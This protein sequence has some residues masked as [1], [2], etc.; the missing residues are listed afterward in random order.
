MLFCY[1]IIP[2]GESLPSALFTEIEDAMD[3]GLHAYGGK[4]F[5]IRYL[6]V[7]QVE[8]GDRGAVNASA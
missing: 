6:E 5:R 8:K 1:A 4:A 3:W 7:A 2:E